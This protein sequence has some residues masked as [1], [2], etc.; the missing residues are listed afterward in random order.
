MSEF[1]QSPSSDVRITSF[2]QPSDMTWSRSWGQVSHGQ[3][4]PDEVVGPL[5][6]ILYPHNY[7]LCR[8]NSYGH[9]AIQLQSLSMI[10]NEIV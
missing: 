2:C 3:T 10:N 9:T 6:T 8:Y 5:H 1:H 4:Q 7:P